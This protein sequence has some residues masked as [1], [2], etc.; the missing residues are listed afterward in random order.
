[1][2]KPRFNVDSAVEMYLLGDSLKVVAKEYGVSISTVRYHLHK[3]GVL[4]TVSAALKEHYSKNQS[5]L[6]GSKRKPHTDEAKIKMSLAQM[7]R[8][9]G[10]AKGTTLKPNGYVEFTTGS[11]KGRLVHTVVMEEF[12][13]RTVRGDE[14]VHHIDRNRS[15]NSI[16]NLAVMTKSAHSRLHRFED[17]LHF[18]KGRNL[19]NGRF[20]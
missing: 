8:W 15:N 5:P 18:E 9:D 13:G 16:D 6:L 19:E 2:G 3:R 7:A 17:G 4:R 11:N 12:L 1:M 20:S 14:C 10:K